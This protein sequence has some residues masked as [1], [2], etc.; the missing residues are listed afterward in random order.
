MQ[1]KLPVNTPT[2]SDLFGKPISS[3]S[4]AQAIEDGVLI[5]IT[6]LA[7]KMRLRFPVAMTS[8]LWVSCTTRPGDQDMTEVLTQLLKTIQTAPPS[9]Q[10]AFTALQ[11]ALHAVIGPGDDPNPVI[12]LMLQ[13]ED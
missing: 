10:L 7:A 5:D 6:P 8:A 11:L 4:R 2:M 13:G 12:T 3:Y 9:D 1:L